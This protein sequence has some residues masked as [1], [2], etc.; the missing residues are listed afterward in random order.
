MNYK[1]IIFGIAIL[2]GTA[3]CKK[4]FDNL[5][6]D[7]NNPST[8]TADVDLYLNQ[9][10]IG[11]NLYLSGS[12]ANLGSAYP[13]ASDFGAQFSRQQYALWRGPFYRSA[14]QP[15]DFDQLWDIS[16]SS[17]PTYGVGG[18]INH[19]N[20][21][22]PLAEQQKK[23]VQA[24]IARVLEAYTYG[25]LVDQFG[26]IPFSEADQ[27]VANPNPKADGGA[28]VYAGVQS[29]LDSALV[30]FQKTGAS[31][32]PANDLFYGGDADKWIALTKTLKLKFYMQVRLVDN[33]VGPKIQALLTENNLVN[34][35][36]QDF[37][38]RYST[39]VSPDSRNPHYAVNYVSSGSGALEYLSNYFMWMLTAQKYGG[40]VTINSTPGST[41]GD[42]RAR[43]YFYRQATNY[44]SWATQTTLQ[45]YPKWNAG[46]YPAW[47]PSIPDQTC[48]CVVGGRGY[49][50]RDFGDNSGANPNGTFTTTWG[51][52]P[53]GGAFD[54][55]SAGG[56]GGIDN[57]FGAKGAGIFPV[58]LSSYTAFLEAEAALALGITTQGDART[59]LKKGVDASIQKVMSF[60]ASIGVIPNPT[61]VPSATM[62][63]NYENLVAA[64]YDT[65]TTDDSRLNIIMTEYYLALWGNGIEP[66]NNLRRTGKP[67]NVQIPVAVPN[68]GFFV[69]SFFYPAV[70]VDRNLNAPAQKN[71]GNVANKVFWDNNPDDFI[72]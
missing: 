13:S 27:G 14:N 49:F 22:I 19:A 65:A 16:Y 6:N 54:D 10:Q 30:D 18:V 51:V 70:F 72:K 32:G 12:P 29:M 1:K 23:Y 46:V 64:N 42:P 35:P 41:L 20:A 38:F 9:V 43:Y 36:S 40:L 34:D 47:Y 44:S 52:Y 3:S 7:P 55:N 66:Y 60:P 67:S 25:T 48:Y 21:L 31:A 24:G 50:G 69:R 11:F 45:C 53:A 62:V 39:S 57:T 2:I 58:W 33:S 26:D 68:P 71:P 8:S 37:V 5:L 4:T 28:A 63:S 61:Y 17:D 56:S 59:L 15:T